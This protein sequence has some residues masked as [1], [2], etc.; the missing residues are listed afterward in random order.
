MKFGLYSMSYPNAS[1]D[2]ND[3][4]SLEMCCGWAY[5]PERSWAASSAWLEVVAYNIDTPLS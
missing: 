3:Q 2:R 5:E 4:K 1:L